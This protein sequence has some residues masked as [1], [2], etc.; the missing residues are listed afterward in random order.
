[1]NLCFALDNK[2][3]EPKELKVFCGGGKVVIRAS[4][5]LW[6]KA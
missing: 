6:I 1:M 4:T 5:A 3:K 2:E